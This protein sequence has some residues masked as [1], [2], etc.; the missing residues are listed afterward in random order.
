MKSRIN[1]ALIGLGYWGANYFRVLQQ[2]KEVNLKHACDKETS[3]LMNYA[4]LTDTSSVNFTDDLT[5]IAEDKEVK[6]AIIVTPASSHY[7]IAKMMLKAGKHVLVEKPLTMNYEQALELCDLSKK[8]NKVPMVGHIYC[9]NPAVNYIR[10]VISSGRL[11]DLYYGVGLRLG[12]G[13]IRN[14]ASCTW[15]LATHD[16]AMLSYLLG[17]M[18]SYV[19][20]H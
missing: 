16:I 20:A 8:M 7:E 17:K 13:P 14:D 1:L 4:E 5:K 19:S 18:P 11:G 12:L 6:V 15:D 3:K 2:L 9:F 10:N